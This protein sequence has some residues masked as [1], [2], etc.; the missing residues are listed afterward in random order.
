MVEAGAAL[1][2]AHLALLVRVPLVVDL[3]QG[4]QAQQGRSCYLQNL[5]VS[6][7]FAVRPHLQGHRTEAAG[8]MVA[9]QR[10]PTDQEAVHQLALRRT[11]LEEQ[12]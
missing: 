4:T 7:M 2:Q 11:H 1:G 6:L 5:Y 9:A 10:P 3:V 12:R 8:T